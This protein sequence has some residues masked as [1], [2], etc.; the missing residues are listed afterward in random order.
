MTDQ[1]FHDEADV[2]GPAKA[3]ALPVG[4][5]DVVY[6]DPPWRYSTATTTPDRR[7]EEQYPTMALD[8]IRALPIGTVAADD[9]VLFLWA[10]APLLPDCLSVVDAWGFSYKTCMVWDKERMGLGHW[11]R[12][13]HELLF[14]ATRG[15]PSLPRAKD[16][17]PMT[18]R[19]VIRE[20]REHHSRKPRQARRAIETMFPDARRLELF[21]RLR[22]AGW[23]GWGNH[24]T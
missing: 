18:I 24:E 20:P 5:Y 17:G 8:D 12:V 21:T 13:Q 10:T 3:G 1:L 2:V 16:G 23:D 22:V 4:P 15:K 11:V 9:S 6:A 7:I 14:I 19:S